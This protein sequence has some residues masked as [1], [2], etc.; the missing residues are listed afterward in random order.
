M[1][2]GPRGTSLRPYLSRSLNA[3]IEGRP[4]HGPPL[5]LRETP[6]YKAVTRGISVTVEPRFMPENRRPTTAVIS[7]PT[8]W[9]S[10][11]PASSAFSC[12]PATG[13]SSTARANP[14][15]ARGRESSESSRSSAR[16]KA[17]ATRAG[18]RLATRE[19]HHA[20]QLRDGDRCGETFTADPAF[21]LTSHSQA[22]GALRSL[23]FR[24][25][26][27]RQARG[28]LRTS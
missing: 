24:S 19:R 4:Y 2:P 11:I 27:P 23:P 21:S 26:S 22:R 5:V 9:K 16:A 17:S 8:R 18:V 1:H 6:M 10:S 20:G 13:K 14:G 25:T 15:S 7:L 12:A 28:S 3:R